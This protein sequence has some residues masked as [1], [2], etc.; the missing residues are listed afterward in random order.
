M[1]EHIKKEERY[2]VGQQFN[3]KDW[4]VYDKNLDRII[5]YCD[6]EGEAKEYIKKLPISNLPEGYKWQHFEDGSGSILGPDNKR[7]FRYDRQP[8]ANVD[9]VEYKRDDSDSWSVFWDGFSDFKCFAEAQI[10]ELTRNSIKDAIIEDYSKYNVEFSTAHMDNV[11]FEAFSLLDAVELYAQ[12]QYSI[13]KDYVFL[14]KNAEIKEKKITG[15]IICSFDSFFSIK[16]RILS[17]WTLTEALKRAEAL[18]EDSSYQL[19]RFDWLKADDYPEDGSTILDG[20]IL[21]FLF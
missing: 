7:Y 16:D 11:P 13:N 5:C 19:I 6:T 21:D 2:V 4:F 15:G 8:Y 14:V 10:R 17:T 9:G 1:H 20:E 12:L 3:T 18:T